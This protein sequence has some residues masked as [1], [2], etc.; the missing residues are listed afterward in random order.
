MHLSSM[1]KAADLPLQPA[2]ALQRVRREGQVSAEGSQRGNSISAQAAS[3]G[4]LT[5]TRMFLRSWGTGGQSQKLP[6]PAHVARS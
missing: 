3:H 2:R 5:L 6:D 1:L 4:V